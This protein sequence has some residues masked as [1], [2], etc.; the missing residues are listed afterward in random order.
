MLF[1]ACAQAATA[2]IP[3]GTLEL[4]AEN[5]WIAPGHAL[6]LG[7]HFQL[8]K[9]W[10]VYWVNPGDSGEPPRLTWHLP[11]GIT[12]GPMEWPTPRRLGTA[13][14]A[15]FGY[16]DAVTLIVPIHA[17]ASL[18][19]KQP[20]QIAA[21]VKVLVCREMCIP[22][23]AQI[24]LTLPIESQPAPADARTSNLF[25]A[26]RKSLPQPAP[27][28]W[29]FSL[30]DTKD[31]FVLSANIG[32][33]ITQAVFFP[34]AES[35]IDNAAQQK[36]QPVPAGFTMTLRKSDQ[37]LKPIDRLKGVLVLSADQ[38]YVIDVPVIK[39]RGAKNS[40]DVEVQLAQSSSNL[41]RT[42]KEEPQK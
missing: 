9:G 20:A 3:H 39:P 19:A 26:A 12:V 28:N 13:T 38:S 33:Q 6:N 18:P 30:T 23:K 34:L 36:L 41:Y 5:Q 1:A 2:T 10:H 40:E 24:S 29:K 4:I 42:L 37:L 27:R 31:S 35:Q 16:E 11:P 14:I 22:G 25:A 32:R 15:D 21:D 17:A 8:E 7:L